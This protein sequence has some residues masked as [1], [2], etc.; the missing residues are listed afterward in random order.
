MCLD[1]EEMVDAEE[2]GAGAQDPVRVVEQGVFIKL[3]LFG[4]VRKWN[5]LK[6]IFDTEEGG[7][8]VQDLVRDIEPGVL[9]KIVTFWRFF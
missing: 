1:F 4:F 3:N 7:A 5:L 6:G 9:V 8:V 2:C